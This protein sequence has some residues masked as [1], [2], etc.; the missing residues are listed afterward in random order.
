MVT[1]TAQ[2]ATCHT[3]IESPNVKENFHGGLILMH[4]VECSGNLRILISPQLLVVRKK[5]W[6]G[7]SPDCLLQGKNIFVVSRALETLVGALE[8]LARAKKAIFL[9]KKV[10]FFGPVRFRLQYFC[11]QNFLVAENSL[12]K[13]QNKFW[14]RRNFW[15]LLRAL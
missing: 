2:G 10:L 13:A 12:K 4:P 3:I 9:A 15:Q 1:F 7:K 11:R 6:V 8:A 5:I 14:A